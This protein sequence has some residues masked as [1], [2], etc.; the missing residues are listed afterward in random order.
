MEGL[1]FFDN[2]HNN[3]FFNTQWFL[4]N[5]MKKT[6]KKKYFPYHRAQQQLASG[7]I[8]WIIMQQNSVTIRTN[9]LFCAPLIDFPYAHPAVQNSWPSCNNCTYVSYSYI[10]ACQQSAPKENVIPSGYAVLP[11]DVISNEAM[12]ILQCLKDLF[13]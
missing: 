5:P 12:A 9:S 13:I 8:H 10:S 11:R 6:N 2:K 1:P 3:F 4:L 7:H